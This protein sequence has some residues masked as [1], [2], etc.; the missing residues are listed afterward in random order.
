MKKKTREI[1]NLT[2]CVQ[3]QGES[4][5]YLLGGVTGFS[6][7]KHFRGLSP[8][9]FTQEQAADRIADYKLDDEFGVYSAVPIEKVR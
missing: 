3:Y 5:W 7:V 4:P 6:E 9:L 8:V 1:R 2:I